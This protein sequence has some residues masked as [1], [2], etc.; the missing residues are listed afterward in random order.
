MN[1]SSSTELI[2]SFEPLS[3]I[4]AGAGAGKTY[5]IQKT[6]TE[7]VKN[8]KIS[9]DRILAV[10]FTKT[11]ANELKERIRIALLQGGLYKES[12]DLQQ[13]TISTIH[14]FGLEIVEQFSYENGSS[15]S[16]RQL[17]EAEENILIRL[18]L[19]QVEK[20]II[21][22]NS[23]LN[24]NTSSIAP[25]IACYTVAVIIFLF[26]IEHGSRSAPDKISVN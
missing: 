23:V 2:T 25:K 14:G 19:T 5:H 17:T 11:A 9:T 18:S 22:L 24:D 10:T 20:I 3:L 1:D 12:Q 13:A 8:N 6:L 4:K 15:P 26:L 21:I 16:P 7:W